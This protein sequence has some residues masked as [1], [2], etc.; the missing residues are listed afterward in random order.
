MD[1]DALLRAVFDQAARWMG[2]AHDLGILSQIAFCA[3]QR[4]AVQLET[5][6]V[7]LICEIGDGVILLSLPGADPAS[8]ENIYDLTLTFNDEPQTVQRAKL[9]VCQG[10]AFGGFAKADVRTAGSAKWREISQKA[11]LPIEAGVDTVFING[12]P[13][14]ESLWS[15]PGW[16]YL[17]VQSG[18]TYDLMLKSASLT[19]AD[20]TMKAAFDSFIIVIK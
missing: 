6:G 16:Y 18:K 12:K 7:L 14:D 11:L 2:F 4:L 15:S 1:L 17:S 5:V 3:F 20:A 19:V 9:A 10:A 13:E 8:G